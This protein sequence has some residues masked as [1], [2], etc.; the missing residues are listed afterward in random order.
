VKFFDTDWNW[1]FEVLPLWERLSIASRE[2]FLLAA[3]SHAQSVLETG[4]GSDLPCVLDE[5][6]VVRASPNRVKPAPQRIEF[7]RVMAQLAKFPLFDVK[8]VEELLEAY[9]KKHFTYDEQLLPATGEEIDIDSQDWPGGF[10]EAPSI[11]KWEKK[12]RTVRYESEY[13]GSYYYA[14]LKLASKQ[15]DPYFKNEDEGEAA[16]LI[17]RHALASPGP[18]ALSAAGGLLPEP[19]R[20]HLAAAFKGCVRFRLLFPALREKT[21]EAVFWV[22]PKMGRRLHRPAPR[23]PIPVVSHELCGPAFLMED[24]AL[25]LTEAAMGDC[26]L[27]KNEWGLRFF[28]KLEEK[29]SADLL[30]LPAWLAQRFSAADRLA[31]ACKLV[32]YLKFG[33]AKNTSEGRRLDPTAKGLEWLKQ[34]PR[35]R[36]HDLLLRLRK[37]RYAELDEVGSHFCFFPSAPVLLD[38]NSEPADLRPALEAVWRAAATPDP[39]P[40]EHFLD[41]HARVSHPLTDNSPWRGDLFLE[42]DYRSVP[43]KPE[44]MEET[45]RALLNQFFWERLIPL[46]AV[47]AGPNGQGRLC[48]RLNPVGQCLVGLLENFEYGHAAADKAALVQP[49]FE[50]VFLQPNLAAEIDL[51]RFAERCGKRV[52]TLFRLT[53]KAAIKAAAMGLAVEDALQSLRDH[54]IKDLPNNVVEELR[55]WFASCR[56]IP[57]RHSWLFEVPEPETALRLRQALGPQCTVVT[58]TLLEYRA[59]NID[60]HVRKALREA[61]I[62]LDLAA[63]NNGNERPVQ[64]AK[65]RVQ[66]LEDN[67]FIEEGAE[68]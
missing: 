38:K 43:M 48:F 11:T 61:G 5:G 53:R 35:N 56:H 49:N 62:F 18:V 13:G 46:G 31:T 12:Y 10:L 42:T 65:V 9:L 45:W 8:D 32:E 51:A 66:R 68:A 41:Y 21:L 52:G 40:L 17:I 15:P 36:L 60:S 6:L 58:D 30:E 33:A 7:R 55:S 63:S 29:L 24:A 14:P 37:D 22:H 3:P 57:F 16:R 50:I 4:Y 59:A 2:H 54:S 44:I 64:K 19:L 28:A 25:I 20:R 1:V 34:S 39:V 26:R 47:D 27:I 67:T 23:V